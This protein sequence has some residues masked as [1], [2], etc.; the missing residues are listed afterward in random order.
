MLRQD[1]FRSVKISLHTVQR[2]AVQNDYVVDV[3]NQGFLSCWHLARDRATTRT[4]CVI[5]I[6]CNTDKSESHYMWELRATN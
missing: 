4:T 6:G 3:L 5:F 2:H 1:P